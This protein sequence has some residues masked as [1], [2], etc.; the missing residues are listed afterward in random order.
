MLNIKAYIKFAFPYAFRM[1][2]AL[3]LVTMVAAFTKVAFTEI[4]DS[5]EVVLLRFLIAGSAAFSVFF[6]GAFIHGLF[7]YHVESPFQKSV[8]DDTSN[9][10]N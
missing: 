2:F 4:N 5:W 10:D 3:F 8:N 9:S 7:K 6:I 1:G